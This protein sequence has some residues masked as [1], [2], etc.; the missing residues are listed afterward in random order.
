MDLGTIN[1]AGGTIIA[2]GGSAS[3]SSNGA[4]GI[5][6]CDGHIGG[7]I[8]I[9]GGNI[10]ATGG[11]ASA[12]IGGGNRGAVSSIN[13]S[14]ATV[15]A[16][17]ILGTANGAA[18]GSGVDVNVGAEPSDMLS[19]GTIVIGP[20]C[21]IYAGGNIGH[22]EMVIGSNE[23]AG[24]SVSVDPTSAVSYTGEIC[25]LA[26]GTTIYP[27]SFDLTI[28]DEQLT[29]DVPYATVMLD[30]KIY[31]ADITVRTTPVGEV[32]FKIASPTVLT[33]AHELTLSDGK[34]HME[35]EYRFYG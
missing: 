19:C 18:I 1:I 9:T 32:T 4:A 5:G 34:K 16:E 31:H 15:R 21:H 6:G 22:G 8:N 35:D 17:L 24:G 12:A 28:N 11:L 14:N 3:L 26:S 23:A 25:P 33:G 7:T 13:I 30:G 27:Y 20:N 2:K 29:D 10:T